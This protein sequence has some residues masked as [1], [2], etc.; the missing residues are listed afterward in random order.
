MRS[1]QLL[2]EISTK[3]ISWGVKAAGAYSWQPYHLHVLIV[4]KYGSLNLLEPFGS[5]QACH[6]IAL[7][8]LPEEDHD[9]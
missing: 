1:T 9:T 4:L 2:T 6:G 7:P 8:V 3:N 5:L